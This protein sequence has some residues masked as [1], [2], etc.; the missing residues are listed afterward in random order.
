MV[1]RD[2]VLIHIL[3]GIMCND[4]SVIMEAPV[5]SSENV[6]LK[7]GDCAVEIA[8]SSLTA[9]NQNTAFQI[10]GDPTE[11]CILSLAVSLEESAQNIK[12]MQKS[13]V[14]VAEIPF[15][16]DRKYMATM[17]YVDSDTCAKLCM[18]GEMSR[19]LHSPADVSISSAVPVGGEGNWKKFNVY[20]Q[21][22]I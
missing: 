12:E 6:N 13:L 14:R 16:S 3:P 20:L 21:S 18:V 7:D 9:V 22:Y 11:T 10:Q 2:N 19:Y 5:E 1:A 15:D 4:G 8:G 17:H